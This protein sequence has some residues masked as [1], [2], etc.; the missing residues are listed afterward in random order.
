LTA[1][2]QFFLRTYGCQMNAHDS[3]KVANLLY[4]AGYVV[5][6]A[7]DAADVLIINTCSI[8]DKAERRLYS[9][10]GMLRAWKSAAPGRV[11]G[12][13]GCV[14]QQEG[15]AIQRR[16]PHVDFVFGTHN[17]RLVPAMLEAAR[18]GVQSL[19]IEESASLDRF[20]LPERHPAYRG[21]AAGRAYLTVMEGCD[22]F[23]SFCVVPRTRGR[24]ISRPADGI[25]AEAESLAGRGVRELT[26]L[27][28]TVNA[29]GR[30]DLRRGQAA[31]AGTVAFAALLRRL[32]GIPGIARL[33]YTSP[34]PLFFEDELIRAHGELPALCPHVHL[35]VQSGSDAVLARMRR[36]YTS[37]DY[38]ALVDDLRAARPDIAITTDLIV[39]FPGETEADFRRTL[40]LVRDVGFVDGFSFKYSARPDT[41]AA[42]MR[43]AVPE[44]VA[45]ARLEELQTRLR[46]L[47]LAAH[48][49][50]VGEATDV[51]VEGDS[52][53]G[54]GQLSGRD[55]YHR[56]V[57]FGAPTGEPP[58]PG[59]LVRVRI[60]EATPHSL[61]GECA[62]EETA[63][64]MRRSVKG[65]SG[66]ADEE[67]RSAVS[68]G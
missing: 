33:R 27:G 1:P 23:C 22:M 13:A 55:P 14:A 42:C 52:R 25:I 47:T 41:A 30:H 45:Q 35:P 46:A 67:R 32:A 19:A 39:G 29:Y 53:R 17:L 62:P 21:A 61:I 5:A 10:L 16:Y 44:D 48:R 66:L 63:G 54:G 37:D 24:E 40:D 3:E 20:D 43:G 28:Q 11:L 65:R 68:G 56:V 64:R 7:P 57:N 9:D 18:R 51:L 58:P 2:K 59:A 6:A 15:D 60:A 12:V 36:R 34:H 50:R 4:H 26:L 38:R 31:E 49:A 8:R